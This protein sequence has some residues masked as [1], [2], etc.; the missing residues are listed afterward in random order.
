[1]G[2]LDSFIK[3]SAKGSAAPALNRHDIHT[4]ARYVEGGSKW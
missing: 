2:L 3:S 4:V 1:M